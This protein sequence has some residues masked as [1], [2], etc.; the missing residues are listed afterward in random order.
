MKIFLSADGKGYKTDLIF[1]KRK[2]EIF[3]GFYG[4]KNIFAIFCEQRIRD[5]ICSFLL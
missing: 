2:W 5:Q 1:N 4:F 3:G